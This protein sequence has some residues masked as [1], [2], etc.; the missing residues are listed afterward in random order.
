MGLYK[1]QWFNAIIYRDRKSRCP[2]L[3][4]CQ[5][6]HRLVYAHVYFFLTIS[7]RS[8]ARE[9]SILLAIEANNARSAYKPKSQLCAKEKAFRPNGTTPSS[10]IRILTLNAQSWNRCQSVPASKHPQTWRE[11]LS[12]MHILKLKRQN[13]EIKRFCCTPG[14]CFMI[15]SMVPCLRKIAECFRTSF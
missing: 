8:K 1:F 4:T 5:N 2:Q 9:Q 15:F 6:F 3:A 11:D 13:G 12:N 7:S 10:S 14:I